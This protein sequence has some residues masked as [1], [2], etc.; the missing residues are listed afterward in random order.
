M[1]VSRG[2]NGLPIRAGINGKMNKTRRNQTAM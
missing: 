2:G 1:I